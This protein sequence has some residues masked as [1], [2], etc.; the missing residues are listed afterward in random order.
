MILNFGTADYLRCFTLINVKMPP[1]ISLSFPILI[2]MHK[3]AELW[4]VLEECFISIPVTV[5]L[6]KKPTQK[7]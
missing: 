5:P 3:S 6:Q 4:Q 7:H 1:C 2:K